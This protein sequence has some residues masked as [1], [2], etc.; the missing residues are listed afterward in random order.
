MFYSIAVDII[1]ASNDD[2]IFVCAGL[3]RLSNVVVI[4]SP[5]IAV[6]VI[7]VSVT[8]VVVGRCCC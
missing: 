1:V 4:I 8:I 3:C 5:L 7:V 2:C 6:L